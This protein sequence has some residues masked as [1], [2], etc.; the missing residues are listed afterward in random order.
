MNWG[1]YMQQHWSWR[2]IGS[3]VHFYI[4]TIATKGIGSRWWNRSINGS[5]GPWKTRSLWIVWSRWYFWSLINLLKSRAMVVVKSLL[6]GLE[7]ILKID[8][9]S[10]SKDFLVVFG[11]KDL[12]NVFVFRFWRWALKQ[13]FL[14]L[15][16]NW[17]GLQSP[18]SWSKIKI[19]KLKDSR[20]KI[21]QF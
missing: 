17:K 15:H 16:K 9:P 2:K 3:D 5:C 8:L 20:V 10:M 18:I 21:S 19:M 6:I 13:P 12:I 11:Y 1:L 14:R 7:R 4:I